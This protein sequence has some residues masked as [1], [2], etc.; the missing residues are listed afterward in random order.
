MKDSIFIKDIKIEPKQLIPK[1]ENLDYLNLLN[2]NQI[3]KEL[4]SDIQEK[5][6]KMDNLD[7]YQYF[8]N[9][10]EIIDYLQINEIPFSLRGSASSS[11]II[12]RQIIKEKNSNAFDPINH[13]NQCDFLRFMNIS[14]SNSLPD[15]DIDIPKMDKNILQKLIQILIF[16]LKIKK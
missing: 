5:D 2:E 1:Y 16:L 14:R 7:I 11:I 3:L 13:Q 12:S 8:V 9:F 10:Q 4:F 6:T 15:I